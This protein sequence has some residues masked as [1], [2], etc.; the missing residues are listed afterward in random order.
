[1]VQVTAAVFLTHMW[2]PIRKCFDYGQLWSLQP[3]CRQNWAGSD[4]PH[5]IWFC[6]S[7]E[8]VDHVVQN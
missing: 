3:A 6:S 8:G 2:D 7:K 4:Y 5:P 1:M